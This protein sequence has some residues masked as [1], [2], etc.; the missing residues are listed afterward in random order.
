MSCKFY[1]HLFKF[2]FSLHQQHREC[3]VKN[4]NARCSAE[5]HINIDLLE[6][7]QLSVSLMAFGSQNFLTPKL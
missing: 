1:T 3:V 6:L 5:T 2:D 4:V 7:L